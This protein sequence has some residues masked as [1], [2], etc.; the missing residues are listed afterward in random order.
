MAGRNVAQSD[1]ENMDGDLR[2]RVN[3]LEHHDAAHN[4][5]LTVLEAWRQQSDIADARK[6][7]QFKHMDA[8]FGSLDR[9]IESVEN[10]LGGKI[11]TVNGSLSWIG[12]LII[13]GVVAAVLAFIVKGGFNLPL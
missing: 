5:R 13:G 7:E 8:R 12:R 1:D 6:D 10:T 11:D 9:K 2:A 4:Q 3:S